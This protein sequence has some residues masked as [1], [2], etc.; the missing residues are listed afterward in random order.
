[1]IE[2]Q[3]SKK[4]QVLDQERIFV[5]RLIR[6]KDRW[7][8]WER[9]DW[10]PGHWSPGAVAG[11]QEGLEQSTGRL[12]EQLAKARRPDLSQFSGGSFVGLQ[13]SYPQE[14]QEESIDKS[15]EID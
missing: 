6:D 14:I 8:R 1:M 10:C 11:G 2:P 7:D 3:P 13:V 4:T 12:Q 5:D 9:W 15:V